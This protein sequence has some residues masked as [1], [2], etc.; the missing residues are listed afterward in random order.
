MISCDAYRGS[1]GALIKML[2]ID[3]NIFSMVDEIHV[4]MSMKL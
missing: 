1:E 4:R 2:P 3:E